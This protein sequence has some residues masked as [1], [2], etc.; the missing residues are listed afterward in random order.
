MV[1]LLTLCTLVCIPVSI[2]PLPNSAVLNDKNGNLLSASIAQD[3]QWRFPLTDSVPY[4][5][6][7]CIL[8][9]EDEY[10][11]AHP[12]IN[13]VSVIRAALQ[14]MQAGKIVSGASTLTMQL[15]RMIRNEERTIV[16]KLFELGLTLRLEMSYSKEELLRHYA[17]MAPFGGNV[18]GLDAASWRYYGRPAHL[19]S[20]SESA[21]L[22]VLPNQPGAIYPGAGT[23]LLEHKRNFLLRKL[24]SRSL[25]DS[26]TCALALEEPL[27]DKPYDL[28]QLAPHLLTTSRASPEVRQLT[29]TLDPWWQHR[30]LEIAERHH[31]H[32]KTN[33][34]DNLAVMVVNMTDGKV[35]AYVGNT[36]D[37]LADG[38]QVDVIQKPRSSGSILKPILYAAALDEGLILPT[39]LL[40]DI[41]TFFGGYSPKNF[42]YGYEGVI[43]ADEALAMSLN[44]PF[45]YLL[46]D[47]SY[48]RFHQDLKA[49][50]ISTLN[51]P[52]GHYGLSL[53]LGGAEV[54]LWDL[55]QVYFSLYRKLSNQHNY[56]L[57][58]T[59][60]GQ[61][62][63]DVK[64]S[65]I[66][67]WQTFLAMTELTRPGNDHSWKNFTS[68]QVI[69][70]KTGTSFGFRDAWAIGLNGDVLVAVWVGNAD[71]EG[72]AG[73]SG[74]SSAGPILTEIIRLS[75][76][77]PTW[78][79]N[80]RPFSVT[81]VI[82]IASGMLAGTEC[83]ETE[84]MEVGLKAERSG[85]CS[86]HRKLWTDG[87]GTY[88]V[89]RTCYTSPDIRESSFFI[90]PPT[91]GYYY[92][93]HHSDY[94]GMPEAF[95][96]CAGPAGD[97]IAINYPAPGAKVFIPRELQ[98]HSGEVIIEASHLNP[99]ATIFWHLNDEFLGT[100][101]LEHK[102][103]LLLKKG[104]Y[105]I[106]LLDEHGNKVSRQ[107]QVVSD[108]S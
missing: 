64:F 55:A 75:D 85:T 80:L 6:E 95:P 69:A 107:F 14:N 26:L 52:P 108:H 13:P 11:Y 84:E 57:S 62:I 49:L 104:S 103:S 53:I 70:W 82:C 7:Q 98:G 34:I 44:I 76:H 93:Q 94:R 86:Y 37:P 35:L 106:T 71:G 79:Q 8:L 9:F 25:I 19:L 43:H 18:V 91:Q 88:A 96:G 81:R 36:S 56:Q 47:Y 15:A 105:L 73:L 83:S 1:P 63:A 87:N 39:T 2:D 51:Q 30:T 17:S 89:N 21:T 68:S 33:G 48:E 102:Q 22:A 5:M 78:L 16:Q 27:P 72:R 24:L 50:G 61:K 97:P 65:E 74:A 92:R 99:E 12:G 41:P 59:G 32:L 45:T 3:G 42:N 90:L 77:N 38:Y 40:P 20:W 60:N 46:R 23:E 100:T 4:K 67:I 29:T 58:F 28:P 31:A 10:F 66:S 101:H 54:K